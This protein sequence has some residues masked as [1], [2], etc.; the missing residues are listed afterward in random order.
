MY[1]YIGKNIPRIDAP[2]KVTGAAEYID[3]LKMYDMMY[4]KVLHS[5]Y[6]HARIVSIDV[7]EAEKVDGVSAVVTGNDI[8]YLGGEALKDMPFLAKEVVRYCGEPIAAVAAETDDIAAYALS[9]IKVE[10]EELPSVLNIDEALNVKTVIHPDL[11]KYKH[12][13]AVKTVDNSN[14]CNHYHLEHG[15]IELG[16]KQADHIFEDEYEVHD[17][18]HAQIEPFSAIAQID[19]NG[20]INVWTTNSSVHR[21]RKDL[22]DA[23]RLPEKNIRIMT[24]YIGGSFGGKGGLKVEPLAIVLAMRTEGRPVKITYSRQECFE[25]TISRHAVRVRL[26]TGVTNDGIITAKK[27]SLYFD[28]GAYSE[29]GP[30][31]CI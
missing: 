19:R 8:D 17:V 2:D 5:P 9:K 21:L 15:D 22:S 24:K 18:H 3:D 16:F 28:T 10:Y 14:I 7:S 25:S 29:K 26:K 6:A 1:K 23:M 30:T 11:A 20:I 31:V 4:G 27:I 13:K 12:I